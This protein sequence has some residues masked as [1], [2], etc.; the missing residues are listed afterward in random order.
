[1]TESVKEILTEFESSHGHLYGENFL[2]EVDHTASPVKVVVMTE[3][4]ANKLKSLLGANPDISVSSLDKDDSVGS[5]FK[6]KANQ[7]GKL[8]H[9][10]RDNR[11]WERLMRDLDPSMI[12]SEKTLSGDFAVISELMPGELIRGLET[13]KNPGWLAVVACHDF[14][15]IAPKQIGWVKI[16]SSVERLGFRELARPKTTKTLDQ[17]VDEYTDLPYHLGGKS[18]A[19]GYDC[20]SLVQQ[21]YFDTRGFWLPKLSAWQ[22]LVGE[23][24]PT[25]STGDLVVMKEAP[26]GTVEHI[27][28]LIESTIPLP[29]VFHASRH[30]GHS[31][32]QDLAAAPWFA[33]KFKVSDYRHL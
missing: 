7:V 6:V 25:P 2:F 11:E 9:Y 1:M 22:A 19:T 10:Y 23:S 18:K 29:T 5:Y 33:K 8:Y 28:I 31:M 30:N 21:I 27:G 16:D 32:V 15:H 26:T 14:E 20:S 4:L 24:T 13:I 3:K 17:A 12:T